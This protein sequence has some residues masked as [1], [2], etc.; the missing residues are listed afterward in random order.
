MDEP[1]RLSIGHSGPGGGAARDRVFLVSSQWQFHTKS[2]SFTLLAGDLDLGAVGAADGFH[3]SKSETS[4]PISRACLVGAIETFENMGNRPRWYPQPVIDYFQEC[5]TLVGAHN[6]VDLAAL[7][8]VL[9]GIV[10]EIH[11][12]LL[13]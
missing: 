3:D 13:K 12:H 1:L 5:L 2:A 7:V 6:H 8:G 4:S 10:D 11:Y 9:D